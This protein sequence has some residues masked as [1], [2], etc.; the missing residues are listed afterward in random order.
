VYKRQAQ[1]RIPELHHAGEETQR[2]YCGAWQR[3]GFHEDGIWS[4]HQLCKQILK[5]DPWLPR[6]A[7]GRASGVSPLQAELPA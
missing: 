7:A 6:L 1:T 3:Y 2:F 4:A 5:R